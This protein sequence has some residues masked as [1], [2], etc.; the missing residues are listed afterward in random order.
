MTEFTER[1]QK[2]SKAALLEIISNASSYQATAVET[3]KLELLTRGVSEEDLNEVIAVNLEQAA[4]Q[5]KLLNEQQKAKK[6]EMKVF[7][8]PINP[9]LKGLSGHEREIR[10]MSWIFTAIGLYAII[11]LI[12]LYNLNQSLINDLFS[13]S[14][15]FEENYITLLCLVFGFMIVIGVVLFWLRKRFGWIL[16]TFLAV[17]GI[18]GKLFNFFYVANKASSEFKRNMDAIM[19]SD[20]SIMLYCVYISLFLY[21]CIFLFRRKT[22]Q[23]FSVT[24]SLSFLVFMLAF[25]LQIVVWS[26]FIN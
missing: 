7:L 22:R 10:I 17:L 26:I 1:Y 3:A 13:M 23:I 25:V 14:R 5:Q 12:E 16:I 19:S 18:I 11:V 2:L 20:W 4:Q 8:E 24:S 21:V 9:F 6:A 15:G